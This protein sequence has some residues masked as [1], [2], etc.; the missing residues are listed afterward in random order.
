MNSIILKKKTF[1][2]CRCL[3]VL[4]KF[5]YIYNLLNGFVNC[6]DQDKSISQRSNDTFTDEWWQNMTDDQLK[7]KQKY[8][9]ITRK[10]EHI[11][12]HS[13]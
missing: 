9:I 7:S 10:K 4:K 13:N 11:P 2:L 12:E 5:Y 3:S 1:F 6:V 8:N